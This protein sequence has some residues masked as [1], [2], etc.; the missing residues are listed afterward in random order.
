MSSIVS[1]EDIDWPASSSESSCP[2]LIAS[3][4]SSSSSSPDNVEPDSSSLLSS[5]E[6]LEVLSSSITVDCP[7]IVSSVEN[8]LIILSIN[9][10]SS[11]DTKLN[12][13]CISGTSSVKSNPLSSS[14]T[15]SKDDPIIKLSKLFSKS[16]I[17]V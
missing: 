9:S 13:S 6:I 2:K 11:V 4:S 17:R 1:V 3:D 5:P 12:K 7:I 14:I 15:S 10:F 8:S 16:D